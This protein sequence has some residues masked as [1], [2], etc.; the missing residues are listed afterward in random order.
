MTVAGVLGHAWLP[1]DSEWQR[2]EAV[3]RVKRPKLDA[4]RAKLAQLFAACRK[5]NVREARALVMHFPYLL[6]LTDNYGFT[7]LHHGVLSRDVEFV[8]QLLDMYH[9]PRTFTRK[10]VRYDTE[11]QL[12]DD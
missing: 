10:F 3:G 1:A 6:A 8:A 4:D 2:A 9:D 5:A 11:E 7:A 12:R